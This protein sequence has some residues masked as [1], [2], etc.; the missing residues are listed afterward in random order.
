MKLEQEIK[1]PKFRNEYHKLAVNIMFSYGWLMNLQSKLF[2]KFGITSN[3]FNILRILRG[4]YPNPVC[5]NLLKERML[6]K[7]SDASRLVE[8]LRVKGLAIREL[9]RHDRRKVDVVITD[10]GLKL[11]AE[12]D[13]LNNEF[14]TQLKNLSL[15]NSK[16]LNNLLDKMR[17]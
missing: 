3:Q 6:D 10:D 8:R 13:K 5:V 1:Q 2:T 4:Q 15:S 14:D 16:T 7:M 11:L 12:I 9:S 17:G